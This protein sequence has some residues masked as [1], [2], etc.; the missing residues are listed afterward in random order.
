MSRKQKSARPIEK[1]RSQRPLRVGEEIRHLLAAALTRS[2]FYDP[3]LGESALLVTE[4]RV[5]SDLRLAT[6]FVCP[7]GGISD[8][9]RL[10]AALGRIAPALRHHLAQRLTLR[11]VPALRF[12]YDDSF[13]RSAHIDALIRTVVAVPRLPEDSHRS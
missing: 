3:D 8:P 5:S 4:V 13:E 11:C 9:R 2:S 6:V 1:G 12:R 7:Q 10:C